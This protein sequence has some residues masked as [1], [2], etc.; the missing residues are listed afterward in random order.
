MKFK[1]MW[2][3][4]WRDWKYCVQVGFDSDNELDSEYSCIKLGSLRIRYRYQLDNYIKTTK[5][6]RSRVTMEDGSQYIIEEKV[7]SHEKE[8]AGI[9]RQET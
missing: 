3:F 7:I 1:K 5:T 4:I 2:N 8:N 6:T 9:P